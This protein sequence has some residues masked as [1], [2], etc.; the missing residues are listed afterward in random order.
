MYIYI[1]GFELVKQYWL[2]KNFRSEHSNKKDPQVKNILNLQ[3]QIISWKMWKIL[4]TSVK[5]SELNSFFAFLC[6]IELGERTFRTTQFYLEISQKWV[7][8]RWRIFLS[9]FFAPFAYIIVLCE[10]KHNENKTKVHLKVAH[11]IQQKIS[12]NKNKL[13]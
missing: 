3:M 5:V 9:S 8:L 1:S 13:T 7:L 11:T 2:A 4:T 12:S 10:L 6:L